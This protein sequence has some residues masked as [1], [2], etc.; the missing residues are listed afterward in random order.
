[1]ANTASTIAGVS[2]CAREALSLV[3]RDVRATERSS[4]RSTSRCSLKLSRNWVHE[5]NR[6]QKRCVKDVHLK[7]L[8]LCYLVTVCYYAWM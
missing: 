7:S 2:F 5:I 8:R 1:M 3:A 6:G 4:S